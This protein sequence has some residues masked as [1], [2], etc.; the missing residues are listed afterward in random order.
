MKQRA[1]AL[2]A[3]AAL[4]AASLS[5]S[6]PALADDSGEVEFSSLSYSLPEAGSDGA[7]TLRLEDAGTGAVIRI[8]FVQSGDEGYVS[9]ILQ[10]PGGKHI[11]M[12]YG[13]ECGLEWYFFE[14]GAA[15][16]LA[17]SHPAASGNFYWLDD[18]SALFDLAE[19]MSESRQCEAQCCYGSSAALVR[20]EQ[21]AGSEL[22]VLARTTPECDFEVADGQVRDNA[23]QVTRRCMSLA[24][25]KLLREENLRDEV[26][27]LPL[28]AP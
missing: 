23:V 18:S 13:M 25:W 9:R 2:F 21:K 28:P 15:K 4:L 11:A 22:S 12:L 10:S 20:L 27:S 26:L 24:D 1:A 14:L 19:D 7:L 6:G 5:W 8:P 17:L 16:Q 3:L